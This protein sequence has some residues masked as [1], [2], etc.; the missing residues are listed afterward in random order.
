MVSNLGRIK[1]TMYKN[2]YI[3]REQTKI[4]KPIHTKDYDHINLYKNNTQKQCLLHVLV[5][6]TFILNPENKP[7]VNH[8]NGIKT[9]NRVENLEWV[10][11]SENQIHAY[12]TGL[13]KKKTGSN[14]KLKKP[15]NQ[16]DLDGNFIKRWESITDALNYYGKYLKIT[17]V[18]KKQKWCKTAGG[19]KWE[20]AKSN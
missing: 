4:L 17:S 11:R 13:Q 3:T 14:S 1:R 2:R 5:A 20:Y 8:K 18:C 7:Q 15:V 9:D 6:K 19:Y 12:K 16:Y 10:T